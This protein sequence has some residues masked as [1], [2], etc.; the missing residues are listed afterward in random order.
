MS[1]YDDDRTLGFD[2]AYELSC[3]RKKLERIPSHDSIAH[4]RPIAE[5][6]IRHIRRCGWRIDKRPMPPMH[7]AGASTKPAGDEE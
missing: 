3:H 6:V 1:D 4:L 2:I 5:A 7:T